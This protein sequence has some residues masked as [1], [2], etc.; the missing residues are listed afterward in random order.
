MLKKYNRFL[1]LLLIIE[2]ILTGCWDSG[3]IEK[4]NNL[5]LVIV[6][7]NEGEYSFYAELANVLGSSKIEIARA[8]YTILTA[9][10]SSL[11]D[12]RDD[13]NR[14]SD[15]PIYLG[16][17]RA[18]IFTGNMAE[19]GLEEY[20]N[21]I[22][23]ESDY[24]KTILLLTTQT[25]P[26]KIIQ[27]EP[28]NARSVGD[29]IE[30]TLE[31]LKEMG[32]G[33]SV[34]VGDVLQ[35]LA[36]E[37]VG[38]LLPQVDVKGQENT[39]TGYT[40]FKQAKCIGFI[41]ASERKGIIYLLGEKPEFYYEV[42][43]DDNHYIINVARDKKRIKSSFVNE[44]V[45]FEVE[46]AFKCEIQYMGKMTQLSKEQQKEV[47][48]KLKDKIEDDI[49][50]TIL[51]SQRTY[52]CDYLEFYKHFKIDYLNEFKQMNWEDKYTQ[53]KI[54]VKI[55]AELVDTAGLEYFKKE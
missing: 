32:Q 24:R 6:D 39:I 14:R 30:G 51:E 47:T 40:I 8:D 50:K 29:S 46:M 9:T 19:I 5:S 18:V 37:N 38:F 27:Q 44:Q 15:H 26:L 53:A 41:P 48:D 45:S 34:S 7:Y 54:K 43:D 11:I 28:E 4:L 55:H 52:R 36:L 42:Y 13:L 20:I 33:F 1:M 2:L 10:E 31:N 49:T 25:D 12:T 23:A 21:R 16:A 22:R 35:K 17:S 3:E